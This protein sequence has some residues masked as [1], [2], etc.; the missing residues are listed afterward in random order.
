[1]RYFRYDQYPR[2]TDI[3]LKTG[4]GVKVNRLWD[5]ERC[6]YLGCDDVHNRHHNVKIHSKVHNEIDANMEALGWS[7]GSIKIMLQN[8]PPIRIREAIGEG[9]VY[10]YM[11]PECGKIFAVEKNLHYQHSQDHPG[12]TKN[13]SVSASPKLFQT[14]ESP[15]GQKR[16]ILEQ[17]PVEE[18]G[19]QLPGEEVVQVRRCEGKRPRTRTN[20]L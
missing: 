17:G 4:D 12:E 16:R 2:R 19:Q 6:P 10:E 9:P 15:G 20:P 13:R 3:V 1:M 11:A 8:N 7:C 5:V 14:L 18:A